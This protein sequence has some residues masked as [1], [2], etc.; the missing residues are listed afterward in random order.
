MWRALKPMSMALEAGR[1][2]AERRLPNGGRGRLIFQ[3]AFGGQEQKRI[4]FV[5][6]DPLMQVRAYFDIGG[7]GA[8]A[9]AVSIWIAQFVGAKINVPDYYEAQG[10]PLSVHL[11]WMRSRGR[12]KAW[13]ILPHDVAHGDK[14]FAT[15]YESAIREA[16]FDILVIPNQGA[17]AASARIET[18]RRSFPRIRMGRRLGRSD[19]AADARQ[20]E[21]GPGRAHNPFFDQNEL[22]VRITPLSVT[23]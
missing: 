4:T 7:T 2:N 16:G 3:T 23:F 6:V 20:A 22:N 14:V 10:Q 1:I 5:P 11:D 9:D 12:G 17:G 21:A 8:R 19:T 15:S 18:A 13:V